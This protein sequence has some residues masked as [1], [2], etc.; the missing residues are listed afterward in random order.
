M[1]VP[2]LPRGLI[3]AFLRVSQDLCCSQ[4]LLES[5]FS[6]PRYVVDPAG[7]V[8]QS[9]WFMEQNVPMSG[10]WTIIPF[11]HPIGRSDST[12]S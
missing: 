8:S 4:G 5:L 1:S 10:E 7:S 12:G 2:F 6:M 11:G 3:F 9:A